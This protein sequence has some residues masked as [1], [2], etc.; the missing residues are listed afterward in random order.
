MDPQTAPKK[1]AGPNTTAA[2]GSDGTATLLGRYQMGRLLGRGSFAKVYR[3][4]SIADG[5]SVAIKVIDK[6]KTVDAAM[7]P[8]ILREVAAMRGLRHSNIL[9]IREVMATKSKIYL[10]MELAEGG[11]VFSKIR[12][13]GR[14]SETAAR[15][16]F[17]QLVAA[18]HYCHQNGV[19]HRDIKPQNLLLDQNN[20]I[21]VSDFGL[22]ALP[23]QLQ[24]GLLHTAC[25]TPAYAAPEVVCRR[26][27]D[28]AKAD[29]WS[30]GVILFVFLAGYLPFDDSNLVNMY[31][32]IHHRDYRFP[33]WMSKSARWVVHQLLDPNPQTRMSIEV[34]MNTPWFKKSLQFSQ[35]STYDSE[36]VTEKDFPTSIL[37]A[38]DIISL[39]SGLDLS[40]L[41]EA[42]NKKDKRF[43]SVASPE[44]IT[45][46]V[47]EEGGKLGYC[48][49]RGKTGSLRMEKGNVLLVVEILE[50][51]PSLL[52]VDVKVAE[53]VVEFGELQWGDLKAGLGD[54]ALQW[55]NLDGA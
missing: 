51:A 31:R 49:R 26:G 20:N 35:I 11:D 54:I 8:R 38:F 33:A 30:C 32:K 18:L 39:S 53:G 16:Y 19:A 36:L 29:A 15:R 52:L 50:V 46:R 17:Q 55:H 6:S 34:L 43:T 41:F 14:L 7:E 23:E 44:T 9:G 37:N 10:V 3:A 47:R 12:R 40:G 4:R 5:G 28:G 21:K 45:E 27:Y 2:D 42:V 25:G 13:C 1:A 22:S 24:H 48:V